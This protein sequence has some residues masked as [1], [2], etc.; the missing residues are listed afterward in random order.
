ML[1]DVT[2]PRLSEASRC[3]Y[4]HGMPN[5]KAFAMRVSLFVVALV[6]STAFS[7]AALA[8]INAD[9]L[10][11]DAFQRGVAELEANRPEVALPAFEESYR[12]RAVPAVLYNIGLTYRGL[13]RHADALEAV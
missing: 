1:P 11:R 3:C 9:T 12:L 6:T 8:Q 7:A 2:A 10:A 5:P 4:S 13:H